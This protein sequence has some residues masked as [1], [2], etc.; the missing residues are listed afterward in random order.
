MSALYERKQTV[1]VSALMGILGLFN[2]ETSGA[3]GD[4]DPTFGSVD[5]PPGIEIVA[6]TIIDSQPM[7]QTSDGAVR[8]LA[9]DGKTALVFPSE[10]QSIRNPLEEPLRGLHA[11]AEGSVL[12]THPLRVLRPDGTTIVYPLDPVDTSLAHIIAAAPLVDGSVLVS[13]QSSLTRRILP[14]GTT[15]QM[16]PSIP[17]QLGYGSSWNRLIPA[18]E[19]RWYVLGEPGRSST[20]NLRRLTAD[21][22]VDRSF[23]PSD[24]QLLNYRAVVPTPDGKVYVS[25]GE[26]TFYNI[27]R[28]MPD[29]S[30][31]ETFS[32]IHSFS[33]EVSSLVY[34]PHT[35][36]VYV[37]LANFEPEGRLWNPL[38]H[39]DG[40]GNMNSYTFRHHS[41]LGGIRTMALSG[42]HLYVAGDFIRQDT[43]E[44][45][46]KIVRL[47]LNPESP[48]P[49][50]VW[51][52]MQDAVIPHD[53]FARFAITVQTTDGIADYQWFK[54][55]LPITDATSS[56]L[57]VRSTYASEGAYHVEVSGT[58]GLQVSRPI[59]LRASGYVSELDPDFAQGFE[60][61]FEEFKQP[62]STAIPLPDGRLF[63]AG[64]FDRVNGEP[65]SGGLRLD[66][67]GSLE[68]LLPVG[69]GIDRPHSFVSDASGNLFGYFTM[70]SSEVFGKLDSEG[71]LE[72]WSPPPGYGE[73][74]FRSVGIQP[75]DEKILRILQPLAEDEDDSL[76]RRRTLLR[77][78]ASGELDASFSPVALQS[79]S[80]VYSITTFNNGKILVTGIWITVNGQGPNDYLDRHAF[81]V[82]AD[83]S[84]DRDFEVDVFGL[85]ES[86]VRDVIPVS[87]GFL[88]WKGEFLFKLQPNGDI[89]PSLEVSLPSGTRGIGIDSGERVYVSTFDQVIR[90][91]PNGVLDRELPIGNES[92]SLPASRPHEDGVLLYGGIGSFDGVP[93][94]NQLIRLRP[95]D[96]HPIKFAD[97]NLESALQLAL[98]LGA[99]PVTVG[100]LAS[101]TSLNLDGAG[102]TDLRGLENARQLETLSLNDNLITDFTPLDAL[103]ITSLVV[104]NN[105]IDTP[106]NISQL[107][108]QLSEGNRVTLDWASD[109]GR[110]YFLE[111]S[112]DL[113]SWQLVRNV[114]AIL[115]D[116]SE[117]QITVERDSLRPR[118]FRLMTRSF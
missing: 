78:H 22:Q 47:D 38:R 23:N 86:P 26:D 35:K 48:A 46:P 76:D 103:K 95:I 63:F 3:P 28:L 112:Y 104:E 79:P 108:M 33:I 77:F 84:I 109:D 17:L 16:H 97:L 44:R 87:D 66:A 1:F 12:A 6:M 9:L 25:T 96:S 74:G 71:S 51:D 31:D 20:A 88:A 111:A 115:G 81:R 82:N 117:H 58:H 98:G 101:V 10:L 70:D 32:P 42:D 24:G 15:A 4:I 34:D 89:D 43:H 110:V 68:A 13:D 106:P 83:G 102:I 53:Q 62:W 49:P 8:K 92:G 105:P 107:R 91:H 41:V 54:D 52:S 5:L 36:G 2:Q 59:L 100:D 93:I 94:S 69:G 19:G 116:G 85:G 72:A 61:Q 57:K 99:E 21:G 40:E 14:D 27:M 11:L 18:G 90:L 45:L 75:M 67:E 50:L 55:G 56:A 30:R 37:G 29:G 7:I 80:D 39:F 113:Q 118:Y 114:S 73:S 64:Q 65:S 60:V